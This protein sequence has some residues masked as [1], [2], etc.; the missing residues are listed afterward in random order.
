MK[1]KSDD[2]NAKTM[3]GGW[4]K[5]LLGGS[6]SLSVSSEAT[7]TWKIYKLRG[8]EQRQT[9]RRKI[10]ILKR[11]E[12]LIKIENDSKKKKNCT[13]ILGKTC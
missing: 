3:A 12:V 13:E 11:F 4:E 9:E 10:D 1:Q 8:D 2:K 6:T 5:C 7:N